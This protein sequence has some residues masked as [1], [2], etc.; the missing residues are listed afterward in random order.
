M[1]DDRLVQFKLMIPAALKL[2]V[3]AE[4][5]ASRRS[6]SQEIVAT[7][8][9]AFPPREDT[10]HLHLP[11]LE[12]AIAEYKAEKSPDRR[13][14]LQALVDAIAMRAVQKVDWSDPFKGIE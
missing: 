13:E 6:L 8:E 3:E 11:D 2:R 14:R 9:A 12:R 1:D 7:L 4:A 10:L 5:K